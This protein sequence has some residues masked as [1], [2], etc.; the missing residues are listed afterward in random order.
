VP[1]EI[2]SSMTMIVLKIR[3]GRSF[4]EDAIPTSQ[5]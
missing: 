3:A 1:A 4:P 5:T 2:A